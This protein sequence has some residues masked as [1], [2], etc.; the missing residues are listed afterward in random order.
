[1]CSKVH[2]MMLMSKIATDCYET[3]TPYTQICVEIILFLKNFS[4][5]FTLNLCVFGI[6]AV[7]CSFMYIL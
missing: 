6:L 7:I 5:S 1:M 3:A 4:I 2:D